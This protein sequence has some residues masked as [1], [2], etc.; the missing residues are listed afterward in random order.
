[1]AVLLPS[2]GA[3]FFLHGDRLDTPQF[4]TDTAQRA[5]WKA[6]YQ[7]FGTIRPVI[8]NLAQNLRFPGQYAD[9]ETGYYHN[10]FRTY[11]ADLGRYLESDPI[12]LRGGINTY[13]YVRA[14]PVHRI[15][16]F[17]LQASYASFGDGWGV[18]WGYGAEAGFGYGGRFQRVPGSGASTA[19]HLPMIVQ[20]RRRSRPL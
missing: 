17:G 16:R 9:Q 15:D 6:A 13:L 1:V 11:A 8:L 4:A 19:N 3:L 10:G 5:E 2:T 7:P 12:G 20:S 18:S 14:N